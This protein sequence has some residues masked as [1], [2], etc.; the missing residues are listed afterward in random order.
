MKREEIL[1]TIRSLAKSQGFYGRL[2]ETIA[3]G[4]EEA[5]DFLTLL[6]EKNFADAVDLVLY[7]ES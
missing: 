6:E 4:S 1:E 3:D 5:E 2:Y 7:F